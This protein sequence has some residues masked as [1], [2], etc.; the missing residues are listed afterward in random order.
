MTVS[1]R[2]LIAG[3]WKMNGCGESGMDLARQLAERMKGRDHHPFD[4]LVCPP[5]TMLSRV[6]EAV[7]GSGILLG[8]QDCHHQPAGAYTGNVSAAMLADVGCAYVIVGHSERRAQH[9]E[10]DAVV[11]AK[12]EAAHIAGLIAIV[13]IGETE[14]E[15]N[16]GNTLKVIK[17]QLAGSLPSS[18]RAVNT[19]IAYEPVWAIGTGRTPTN[20]EVEQVHACIRDR[21]TD[22]F[23]EA[24][25][26]ATRLL[27]GGSMN[28]ENAGELRA[29]PDVDGGLVG[30]AGLKAET[31]WAICEA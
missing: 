3:N 14:A 25:A 19:V 16:A 11:K 15:R 13:C 28:A 27:Y 22:D 23:G 8:A 18:M 7:A 30:G 10:T 5:F 21:L 2:P 31:F 12:A 17:D 20:D 6:G 1:R 9:G 24:E 26:Q 29:L 4:M